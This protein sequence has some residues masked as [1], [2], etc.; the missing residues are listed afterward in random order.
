VGCGIQKGRQ[1]VT[2]LV[3]VRGERVGSG[4]RRGYQLCDTGKRREGG[5]SGEVV[6]RTATVPVVLH[7]KLRDPGRRRRR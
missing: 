1:R 5:G 7:G 4:S 3:V 2:G 6:Q